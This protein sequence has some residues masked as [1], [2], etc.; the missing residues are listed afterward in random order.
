MPKNLN[1]NC[2]PNAKSSKIKNAVNTALSAVFFLC[3][4]EMSAVMV[5]K[6]G[7]TPNGFIMAKK[8]VKKSSAV[9]KSS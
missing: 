3:F 8:E 6:T 5:I 2:P 4:S 1:S 7:I 9:V